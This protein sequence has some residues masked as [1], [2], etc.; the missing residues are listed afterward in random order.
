M[1]LLN[2]LIMALLVVLL[3]AAGLGQEKSSLVSLEALE[4]YQNQGVP[5]V[6]DLSA[7]F[8]TLA[9][10]ILD[11]DAEQPP[12]ALIPHEADRSVARPLVVQRRERHAPEPAGRPCPR[13][14]SICLSRVMIISTRSVWR[15]QPA[16][17]AGPSIDDFQTTPICQDNITHLAIRKTHPVLADQYRHFEAELELAL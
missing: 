9:H 14:M 13:R 2:R 8:R 3:P 16:N 6:A 15:G 11:A 5:T 1:S 17:R 10:T 12:L 4:R 7:R